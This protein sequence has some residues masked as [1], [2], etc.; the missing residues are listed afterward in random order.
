M[1]SL[2]PAGRRHYVEAAMILRRH[3]VGLTLV[4]LLVVI[5]IIGILIA[6]LLP[7]V[8]AA[9]EAAR[10]L[11]C[12]NNLKQIGLALHNYASA[13]RCFPPGFIE[14]NGAHEAYGQPAYYIDVWAEAGNTSGTGQHGTSWMLQ[15]LPYIEQAALYNNWVFTT[16]VLDNAVVAQTDIPGFYCPSR[17]STV[18]TKD[19]QIMFQNWT[20]GGTDYGGC[21]GAVNAA[22]NSQS[23]QAPSCPHEIQNISTIVAAGASPKEV[24]IFLPNT[25]VGFAEIRDGTSNTLMT[26]ELQRLHGEDYNQDGTGCP[27]FTQ[28][29][30]AVGGMATLFDTYIGPGN[31]AGGINNWFFESPGS[32]HPGGA[33]FGMADGSVR[34]ISENTSS[35]LLRDM[36]S[37]AGGEV[38]SGG[39]F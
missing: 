15:I 6:L 14:V 20:K 8:Q 33:Q 16:N 5:A 4:E 24:G 28:D 9:R 2:Q 17:R 10:R 1:P 36:A 23:M 27:E 3:R 19:V 30:W 34:F 18:R 25:G 35:E 29:G 21:I 39:A 22:A 31:S 7:A 11:H 13:H 37:R 26:G 38:I 12:A 32:E